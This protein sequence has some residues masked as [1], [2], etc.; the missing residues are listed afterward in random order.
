VF[1][2]KLLLRFAVA[3]TV[4]GGVLFVSAGRLDLPFF[5]AYL[6]GFAGFAILVVLT[7]SREL[8]EERFKP[9][10]GGRD[11]LALVRAAAFVAS[12]TQWMVA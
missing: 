3:T 10:E 12:S 4:V 6:A 7:V 11:K 5:W 2:L 1:R 8:L 9:G